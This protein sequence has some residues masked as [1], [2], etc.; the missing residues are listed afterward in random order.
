M[1]KRE[2]PSV[3]GLVFLTVLLDM[4]G[5][6]VIFPLFPTMLE[7][8]VELEGQASLIGR[9]VD[10]LSWGSADNFTVV[11]LFGGVLGSIYSL[12]QF[13]FAPIWGSLS[14][15]IG[16]RPT[17]LITL[18]GTMFSYVLWFVS[19]SFVVFVVSRLV[20]G[21]MAGN[22][23]TAS[24]AIA[25]SCEGPDRAKG[26]GILG[27][28]IGLGFVIGP[29]L[30]GLTAS[31]NLLSVWPGG[32]PYGVNPFSGCALIACTLAAV[33]LLWAVLRFP[34]TRTPAKHGSVKP[35]HTH[36]EPARGPAS[37]WFAWC[38]TSELVLFLLLHRLR[39]D[40]VHT[41][42]FGRPPTGVRTSG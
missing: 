40:G 22:V 6:S 23:S 25:D 14:D 28:G 29:A 18:T 4:M 37:D 9:L 1:T 32:A 10:A 26:M 21:V 33:N 30:G 35:R 17:M 16:R 42:L 24:A 34:E 27:A 36:L 7:H 11:A 20:G 12:S 38:Q 19:G 41:A 39:R 31:W 3:L 8:Y 15:R 13:V 2:Q 5:F